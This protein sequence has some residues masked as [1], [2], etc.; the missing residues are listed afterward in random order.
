MLITFFGRRVEY[1][2]VSDGQA[3][4]EMKSDEASGKRN[5]GRSHV[6]TYPL[7]DFIFV[8]VLTYVA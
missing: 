7:V 2:V 3:V 5:E 4:N 8:S 6:P 1:K